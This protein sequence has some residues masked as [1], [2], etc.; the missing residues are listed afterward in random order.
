MV[1]TTFLAGLVMLLATPGPTN[2]LLF[3]AGA[4]GA[5]RLAP[6]LL[7][8]EAMAYLAAVTLLGF[9]LQPVIAAEPR[10]ALGLQLLAASYLLHAAWRMWHRPL[11]LAA[12]T[13]APVTPRMIAATTLLN[14]KTLII[15][16]GLMPAGWNMS[17][18]VAVAHLALLA[19]LVP[20]VG[21]LWFLAGH[22][23]SLKA[24]ARTTQAIVPRFSALVLTGF[25]VLL[26]RSALAGL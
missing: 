23:G 1:S 12:S 25:A 18:S 8:A 20:L 6:W 2:T 5:P 17:I 14:P 4:T 22:L 15:A 7:G 3:V 16:F 13:V 21:G 9:A 19:V 26:A 11:L 10:L 24:S